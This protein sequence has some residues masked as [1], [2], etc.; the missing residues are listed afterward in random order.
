MKLAHDAVIAG[1]LGK[2]RTLTA[3]RT[4]YFWPTMRIDIDAFVSNCVKCV[5]IEGAVP[6][7]ALILENSPPD[8]H[9]DVVS[10]DLLQLPAND[11]GTKYLLAVVDHMS[12]Y[13]MLASLKYRLAKSV[14]HT[15]VTYL[16][17]A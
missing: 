17:C 10:I 1:H 14:A 6:R 2:E 16:F 11:Q 5:E 9:Q 8:R 15:L 12:R 4:S 7:P 3:T 13:T